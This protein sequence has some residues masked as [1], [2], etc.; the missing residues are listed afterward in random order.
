M[1]IWEEAAGLEQDLVLLSGMGEKEGDLGLGLKLWAPWQIQ[2]WGNFWRNGR[3]ET[4]GFPGNQVSHPD[5]DCSVLGQRWP[6][7]QR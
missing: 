7:K 4:A 6:E 2:P 1:R 5:T 3:S